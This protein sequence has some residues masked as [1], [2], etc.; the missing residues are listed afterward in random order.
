[1]IKDTALN[2]LG[3]ATKLATPKSKTQ[4]ILDVVAPGSQVK[5]ISNRQAGQTLVD[6]ARRFL[7]S[8]TK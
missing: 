1:M 4:K 8:K 6:T 2:L 5:Q 7:P 3:R